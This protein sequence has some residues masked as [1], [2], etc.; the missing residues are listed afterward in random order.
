MKARIPNGFTV[1]FFE[2]DL[3]KS[4][5]FDEKNLSEYQKQVLA[6]LGEQEQ[7][8]IKLGYGAVVRDLSGTYQDCKFN[9]DGYVPP[10]RAINNLAHALLPSIQAFYADE[11]NR[12]AYEKFAAAKNRPHNTD[13]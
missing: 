7:E 4:K 5:A 11:K 1:I 12:E 10:E 6:Q 13:K 3:S 8:K 2:T 9:M